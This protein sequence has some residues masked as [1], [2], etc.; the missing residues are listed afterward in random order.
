MDYIYGYA[1]T[2]VMRLGKFPR[3]TLKLWGLELGN[4]NEHGGDYGLQSVG[5][6][7]ARI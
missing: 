4:D 2:M 1:G 5:F 7:V 3:K 6:R